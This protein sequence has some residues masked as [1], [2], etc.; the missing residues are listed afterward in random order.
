MS[1]DWA[2]ESEMGIGLAEM[3]VGKRASSLLDRQVA[4]ELAKAVNKFTMTLQVLHMTNSGAYHSS[5]RHLLRF[6][7]PECIASG[8]AG[9]DEDDDMVEV[10]DFDGEHHGEGVKLSTSAI[11][12]G[13][14]APSDAASRES[15]SESIS[16]DCTSR[17]DESG[18]ACGSGSARGETQ[19]MIPILS[20]C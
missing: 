1:N 18:S 13:Q 20:P 4:R 8:G 19:E 3:Y 14:L 7:D 5:K 17:D 2:S 10:F 6:V 12:L 15:L 16:S 9:I 11:V